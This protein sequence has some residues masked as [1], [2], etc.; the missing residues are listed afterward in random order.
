LY[1]AP[2]IAKDF[3]LGRE[4]YF[5]TGIRG[6]ESLSGNYVVVEDAGKNEVARI[7]SPGSIW[8]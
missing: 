4:T 5:A 1:F 6:D 3:V 8:I 7:K 2:D